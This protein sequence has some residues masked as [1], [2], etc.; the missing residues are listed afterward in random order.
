MAAKQRLAL[1]AV[2]GLWAYAIYDRHVVSVMGPSMFPTFNVLGETLIIK[3]IK[4]S[5]VELGD[6][7]TLRSPSDP[8]KTVLKR[9][10]ALPG[11]RVSDPLITR[12][13]LFLFSLFSLFPPTP[14]NPQSYQS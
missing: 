13:F 10:V 9:V 1:A 3:P 2:V 12:M 11:S 8:S 14:L 4:P 6:L 5:E 7:V